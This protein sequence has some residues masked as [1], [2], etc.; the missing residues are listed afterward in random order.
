[1]PH[2]LSRNSSPFFLQRHQEKLSYW[3]LI[4]LQ[5]KANGCWYRGEDFS[6]ANWQWPKN[7]WFQERL[8]HHVKIPHSSHGEANNCTSPQRL[9]NLQRAAAGT[10]LMTSLN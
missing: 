5:S 9:Q 4:L 6:Q 3:Q 2:A 7:T 8:S 1:M 10:A